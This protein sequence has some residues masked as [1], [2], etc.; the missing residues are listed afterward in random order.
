MKLNELTVGERGLVVKIETD[1]TL[2]SR[3]TSLG[4]RIGSQVEMFQN[5]PSY[6]IKVNGLIKIALKRNIAQHILVDYTKELIYK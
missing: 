4:L 1:R 5:F 2:W 6:I 3:I